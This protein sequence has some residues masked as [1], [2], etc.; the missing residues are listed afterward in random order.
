MAVAQRRAGRP[1]SQPAV[2]T[3]AALPD[4]HI[5]AV[6]GHRGDVALYILQVDN[7]WLLC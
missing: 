6:G 2:L 1:A 5:V 3:L 7:H 4:V